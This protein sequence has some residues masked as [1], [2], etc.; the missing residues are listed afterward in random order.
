MILALILWRNVLLRGELQIDAQDLN[1]EKSEST[2][3]MKSLSMPLM[4][5]KKKK[6]RV[7]D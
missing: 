5:K 1:F 7:L 2:P 3:Y 6:K 4:K